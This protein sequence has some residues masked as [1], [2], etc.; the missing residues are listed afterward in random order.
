MEEEGEKENDEFSESADIGLAAGKTMGRSMNMYLAQLNLE[1]LK[2]HIYNRVINKPCPQEDG[3]E[4]EGGWEVI[5][6]KPPPPKP[7]LKVFS[8]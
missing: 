8:P 6:P 5:G 1:H 3:E 4:M 2:A 7:P